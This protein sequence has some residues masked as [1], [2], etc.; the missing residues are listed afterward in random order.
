MND[1]FTSCEEIFGTE[2]FWDQIMM[3][4]AL[5][6]R[7][8]LDPSEEELVMTAQSFAGDYAKLLELTKTQD[9][10]ATQE[11]T[12]KT[13]EETLKYRDFKATGTQ[14]ILNREIASIILPLLADHV[15]REANH[16]IRILQCMRTE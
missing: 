12:G 13:L 9:A 16:Y 15:L 1:R 6:I 4:H 3:E 5:F 14:G 7:G 2:E 8:L 11:L 10:I